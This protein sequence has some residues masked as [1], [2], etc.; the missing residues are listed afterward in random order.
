M[1]EIA[2][3]GKGQNRN[4]G[5]VEERE[6]GGKLKVMPK[7]VGTSVGERESFCLYQ[8]TK[9][10]KDSLMIFGSSSQGYNTRR[11]EIGWTTC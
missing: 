11:E 7:R 10:R 1:K 6:A 2:G 9:A 4:S 8:C 5:G 3:G